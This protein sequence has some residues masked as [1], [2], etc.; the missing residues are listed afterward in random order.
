[1]ATKQKVKALAKKPVPKKA[2]EKPT[3]IQATK[4]FMSKAEIMEALEV[5]GIA[6]QLDER[7]KKLFLKVALAN[8][9]N[10]FNHEIHAMSI[11]D[12]ESGKEILTPATGYQVY[13]RRAEQSQRVEYWYLERSGEITDPVKGIGNYCSTLVVKR[14]DW[15]VE[16]RWPVRYSE[17]VRKRKPQ[18]SN[19]RI[20]TAMWR[21]RPYF[22]TDKNAMSGLRL[23]LPEILGEMPYIAEE[24]D[25]LQDRDAPEPPPMVQPKALT[26]TAQQ[27]IKADKEQVELVKAELRDMASVMLRSGLYHDETVQADGKRSLPA[28]VK[29]VEE[30]EASDDPL[31]SLRDTLAS[32]Q[33]DYADRKEAAQAA[34]AKAGKA[35]DK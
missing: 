32:W 16:W 21:D 35:G 31:N 25:P 13:I 1:M 5:M 24:L 10:P 17:V 11:W 28:R 2:P 15:R 14:K 19:E 6:Q 4:P 7:G 27:E 33:I 23:I 8:R 3:V 30:A 22:M 29:Q 18:G 12:P 26:S 9:L 34:L 20:P